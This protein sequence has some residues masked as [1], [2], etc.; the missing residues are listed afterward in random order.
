MP[1]KKGKLEGTVAKEINVRDYRC[2]IIGGTSRGATT[3]LFNYLGTNAQKEVKSR[4]DWNEV[5]E[6]TEKVYREITGDKG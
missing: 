5:V 6:K 1:V 3:S 2:L 4:F